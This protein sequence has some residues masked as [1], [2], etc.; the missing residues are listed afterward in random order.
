MQ[1]AYTTETVRAPSPVAGIARSAMLV[2]LNICVYSGRRMD[3]KT[4]DEV[5][6]SK[7]S[8][9]KR[10]ASVYKNLFAECKELDDITKFASRVRAEH[11]RLTLPWSDNGQRLLPTK[12]LFDYQT[13]M[14][15]YRDEF[16]RLVELFLDKYDTLV[17]AAAFQL[18]GLFDRA[19]YLPRDMVRR[20][21]SI[22]TG[23]VPVPLAGDFRV[24]I[25]AEVQQDLIDQFERRMQASMM[26]A[27]RDAWDRL[28][29]VLSKI[30]D[31]LTMEEDGGKRTFHDTMIGN[32][33]ELC[34][35][36]TALNVGDD[37]KLE[38][39]RF[40]LE[41]A[42]NGVTPK[43]LREED[44]TRIETKRKVDAIL[45]DFDWLSGD[46]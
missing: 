18:G 21:F 37:P 22:D 19:E 42:L 16:E 26:Q 33:E 2:D 15:R 40:R 20:R 11:Y 39:A 32:A 44:S 12:C 8:G 45:A 28:Y 25:E 1:I 4:Q 35:L 38:H 30:S 29:K 43:V 36:L 3:K 34:G 14:N 13:A 7:S 24:E 27:N 6:S 23:M 31:R 5:T 17:A 46:E 10:A 9:S 41:E